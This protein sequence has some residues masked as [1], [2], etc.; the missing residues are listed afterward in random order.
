VSSHSELKD[1]V[2]AV[3]AVVI[4]FRGQLEELSAAVDS[5]RQSTMQDFRILVIDDRPGEISPPDFLNG[6]EYL[7]SYGQGL[8]K[9]PA[10]RQAAAMHRQKSRAMD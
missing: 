7:R 5:V 2:A 10:L 6:Q 1:N 8:S 4:P 9:V 3:I